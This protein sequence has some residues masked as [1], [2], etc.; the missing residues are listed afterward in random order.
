MKFRLVSAILPLIALAA[1]GD[2]AG[3]ANSATPAAPVAA[4][5]APAGQDWTQTV[6]QTKEGGFVMGNPA[7][8]LKLVEYGSRLC[9]T[10]GAFANTGMK[11]LI[12]TYVKSGK[13][14]YEFREYLVHG[15]P[16]FAPALLG[17]CVGTTAFFPVLEQMFA[18]QSTILPKMEDAQAFQATLQ[19]KPPEVFATAWAEKLGYIDFVKQRGLPEAK[20]RACLTDK[21]EIDK[22]VKNMDLGTQMGVS[23]TPSFFLNG[24]PLQG[25]ISWEQVEQQLKGAG[26]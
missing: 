16:D 1:C 17:R 7:A 8:P 13:V 9:P 22:M 25:A 24:N 5:P 4:A 15:A 26:A 18:A 11:P 6:A 2:N 21:A 19:G 10:C 20:A 14:S 12:D 23:G 3:T